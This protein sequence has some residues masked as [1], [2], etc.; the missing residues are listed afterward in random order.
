MRVGRVHDRAIL[1]A[2][3]VRA[4][5]PFA[6]DVWRTVRKDR[7]P[8]RGSSAHGRWSP[9]GE[10][11]VL[12]TSLE[13]KG[14][15]AEIGY[16]LSLEPVWPSRIAH[17]IHRLAIS[18]PNVLRFPDLASLEPLGIDPARY[19]TFEYEATQAVAA[20]AHFL[21]VDGLLVPSARFDCL[22]AV[23]FTDRP[24]TI[25]VRESD[26]ADWDAWGASRRRR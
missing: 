16:R 13:R 10:F 12:Y 18:V 11:E 21:G 8:R 22:N 14:S 24:A 7:D 4:G 20:A 9:S 5:E 6:G 25:A 15:L 23:L 2:L 17:E 19:P 1:D 3:E 26:T